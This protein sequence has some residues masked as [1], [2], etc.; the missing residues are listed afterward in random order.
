M[1]VGP[2]AGGGAG[3]LVRPIQQERVDDV[4]APDPFG[5]LAAPPLHSSGRALT[6]LDRACRLPVGGAQVAA[7]AQVRVV[8]LAL[9][10]RLRHL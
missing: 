6:A 5:V 8:E 2:G 1:P 7:L 10:D 4:M 3:V 9:A